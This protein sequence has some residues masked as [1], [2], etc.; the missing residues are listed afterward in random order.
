[1][2]LVELAHKSIELIEEAGPQGIRSDVLAGML[3]SP[4]RRVY[5]IVAVLRALGLVTT[6]RK[7]DGTTLMWVDHSADY[8]ERSEH[9]AV[10]GRLSDATAMK[11]Q[12]QVEV[13]ELKEQ[14]R[15]MRP[16]TPRESQTVGTTH[17][18]EFDTTQLRVRATSRMGFKKVT[19]SGM[20]VV[21]E[22]HDPG[23]TVD[24][25]EELADKVEALIRNLDRT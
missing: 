23:M 12:L 1:L 18:T 10:K 2:K 8:V 15:L 14:L 7:S 4:K 16:K 20:E 6:K 5:D 22:T 25:S 24:P 17:K 9:E 21:I 11:N 3:E 13:A 19:D